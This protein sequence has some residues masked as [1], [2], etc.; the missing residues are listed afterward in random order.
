MT[1]TD[2]SADEVVTSTGRIKKLHS[3]GCADYLHLALLSERDRYKARAERA[4]WALG[5]YA[6]ETNWIQTSAANDDPH[7]GRLRDIWDGDFADGWGV[8]RATLAQ[9]DAEP[10]EP[11]QPTV[12]EA[13]KV[14]LAD[15]DEGEGILGELAC[16]SQD[17]DGEMEPDI[18]GDWVRYSRVDAALRAFAEG[19]SQ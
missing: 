18:D 6:D 7:D 16:F 10:V 13:A 15:C 1:G 14:L 3:I 5:W 19:D 11:R 17:M 8:A 9:I 4:E 2:T 12:Q